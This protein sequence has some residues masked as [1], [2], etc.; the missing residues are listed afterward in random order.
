MY[1]RKELKIGFG[2]VTGIYAGLLALVNIINRDSMCR[3]VNKLVTGINGLTGV[4]VIVS[5][6]ALLDFP[7]LIKELFLVAGLVN[8][9]LYIVL[10]TRI[11]SQAVCY[12]KYKSWLITG[13]AFMCI[14]LAFVIYDLANYPGK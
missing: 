4:L 10:Y 14:G 5:V 1:V 11:K 7:F 9:V 2:I 13:L 3:D 8:I 6:L 12:G